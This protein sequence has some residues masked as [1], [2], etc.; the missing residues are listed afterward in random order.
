[1]K[2]IPWEEIRRKNFTAKEIK[3]L[4]A[5]VEAELLEMNLRA[6]RSHL[7]KTQV[8]LAKAAKMS[9]PDVS[10]AEK[11]AD[12]LV[13]TLRRYVKALGGELEVNA[14]FGDLRIQLKGV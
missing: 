4:D 3:E 6:L 1:M 8:Q 7:K 2:T 11:R 9:Q 13:S 5:A 10:A 14:R 12:H